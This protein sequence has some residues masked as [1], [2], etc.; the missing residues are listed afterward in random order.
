MGRWLIICLVIGSF[1]AI[2]RIAMGG[3]LDQVSISKESKWRPS[4]CHLP[5]APS[6]KVYDVVS[7][8]VAVSMFNTYRDEV[9][10]YFVCASA[11]A[12]SDYK[13][14]REVLTANLEG[15]QTDVMTQFEGLKEDLEL[16]RKAFE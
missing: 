13:G 15:I 8:N 4:G 9:S 5:V 6:T 14:F 10:A 3:Q 12:E 7:Y 16:S 11:E 1:A 2:P